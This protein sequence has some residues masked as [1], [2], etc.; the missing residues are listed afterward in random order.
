GHKRHIDL[1]VEI[2]DS[3]LEAVMSGE[4]WTEVV[5]KV[6]DLVVDHKTTLVFVNTR[7]LAERVAARLDEALTPRIGPKLVSAHHG[8]MSKDKRLD[9]EQRLKDGKLRAL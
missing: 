2:P 9:A 6:S 5:K 7:R 4:V 3:P 8:S 1:G